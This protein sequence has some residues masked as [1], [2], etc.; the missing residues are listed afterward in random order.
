V[1]A[2]LIKQSET[3]YRMA[4]PGGPSNC[5]LKEACSILAKKAALEFKG[6]E[7]DGNKLYKL[8]HRHKDNLDK[9]DKL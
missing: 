1:A 6:A 9:Q 4:Q 8:I 5:G 7:I 2:L 3:N